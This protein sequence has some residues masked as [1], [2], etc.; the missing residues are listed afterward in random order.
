MGGSTLGTAPRMADGHG[1]QPH[2]DRSTGQFHSDICTCTSRSTHPLGACTS[3]PITYNVSICRL[4]SLSKLTVTAMPAQ[5]SLT[6]LRTRGLQ[7][8]FSSLPSSDAERT[9]TPPP[10]IGD[11]FGSQATPTREIVRSFGEPETEPSTPNSPRINT[12]GYRRALRRERSVYFSTKAVLQYDKAE[13]KLKHWYWSVEVSPF[14]AC[15][16]S[17]AIDDMLMLTG[18]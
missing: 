17:N 11:I 10:T 9:P 7:S 3:L 16:D 6:H 5:R 8:L 1:E 14:N 18:R 15:A 13:N 2:S 12:G 4:S